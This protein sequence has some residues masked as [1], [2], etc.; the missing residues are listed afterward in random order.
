MVLPRNIKTTMK[1]LLRNRDTALPSADPKPQ[2]PTMRTRLCKISADSR[3]A[4]LTFRLA[5]G[6]GFERTNGWL[7]ATVTLVQKKND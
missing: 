7:Q 5:S 3:S 1:L 4:N 6:S 2:A